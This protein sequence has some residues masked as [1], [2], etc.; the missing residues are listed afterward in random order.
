LREQA[1]LCRALSAMAQPDLTCAPIYGGP[2]RPEDEFPPDFTTSLAA[3]PCFCEDGS[4]PFLRSLF[5]IPSGQALLEMAVATVHVEWT[6]LSSSTFFPAHELF[7]PPLNDA[8]WRGGN[9]CEDVK[10]CSAPTSLFLP[11]PPLP[12]G[13]LFLPNFPPHR[14][15][16]PHPQRPLC[17][18][19]LPR[20]SFSMN[21]LEGLF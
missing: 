15:A 14:I 8:S 6:L 12:R 5:L 9:F 2:W 19:L 21:V 10:P 4:P 17:L 20:I 7:C 18:G 3:A 16:R 13:G 11:S 1:S